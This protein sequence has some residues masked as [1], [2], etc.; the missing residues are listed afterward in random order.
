MAHL[1]K[2]LLDY[3]YLDPRLTTV[4]DFAAM[5]LNATLLRQQL[6]QERMRTYL[7]LFNSKQ[8]SHRVSVLHH[9]IDAYA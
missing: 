8:L 5:R 1:E 4:E 6:D 9:Y 7:S 2:A 3:C